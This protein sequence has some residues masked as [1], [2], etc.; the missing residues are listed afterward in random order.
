MK[1]KNYISLLNNTLKLIDEYDLDE[2]FNCLKNIIQNEG[3][4]ILCGNGGSFA[5]ALHIAGDF[6]KTFAYYNAS[7]HSIG[8]N[9][10][11][12]SAIS[13]DYC[14][15]EAFSIQLLPLIKKNI[16]SIVIFLSGS[17]N[18]KNII[19]AA[20]E[21]AKQKGRSSQI[22]TFSISAY[23]GGS[24]KS[25]VNFPIKLEVKDMEI[26]EDIQLIIFHY[27]KQRLIKTFPINKDNYIKYDKRIND[28]Y[29]A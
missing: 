11:S 21:L 4:V 7:F 23:G 5:N 22:N 6:Q 28:G 27:L 24:I 29:I 3:T 14:F 10:C 8:E 2:Y 13:N 16:P 15:E 17:G 9:F 18:S 25:L 26:A 20:K 1:F 12:T 19:N